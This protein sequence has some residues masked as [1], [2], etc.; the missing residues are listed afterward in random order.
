MPGRDGEMPHEHRVSL[1]CG[2]G[3][4]RSV[5]RWRR[6]V[7]I[8]SWLG[9]AKTETPEHA[10]LRELVNALDRLEPGRARYLARFAYLLGRVAHADREVSRDETDTMEQLVRDE[11]QVSGEQAMLV[12]SLAKARTCCLARLRTSRSRVISRRTPATPRS[13]RWR[14]VSSRS[15]QPMPR[16]PWSR[17]QRSTGYSISFASSRPI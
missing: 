2:P 7:S 5:Y 6:M 12:V 9:L 16:S 8:A 17:K 13:S 14:G 15:Q 1:P 3:R 11:G 10:P 4:P